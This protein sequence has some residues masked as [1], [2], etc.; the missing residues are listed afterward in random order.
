MAYTVLARRYRSSNFDQVI[1][2]DH[3]AQTLKKAI[4]T[5]RIAHAYLFCGTRGVGK[6]SMARILAKALNCQSFP[7]P[8]DTPCGTCDSCQAIARGEDIDVIEIDAAS[9]TGVDNVRDVI[10]N[11]AYRPVRGRFKIFIIDEVHMLSKQAFN[12]LL[13]TLEEPPEHVKFILAT[14]E[15][16]KLPATILSRCQRYD[17]RNISAREIAGHL[18]EICKQ[19]KIDADDDA[20]LLVAKAGCGSMRDALSLLDRLLSVGEKHVNVELVEQLLGLPKAQVLFDLAEGIAAADVPLTLTRADAIVQSGMSVD[21]LLSALVDHLHNLLILRT[22]GSSSDLVEVPGLAKAEMDVQ[23]KKFDA[24]VLVQDIAIL[25]ELRRTVR[26]SQAGRALL[27]ATLVR[28]ALADQ[29]ASVGQL[30]ANLD[31]PDGAAVEPG[32]A[33]PALKKNSIELIPPATADDEDDELPRPGKVFAGPKLSELRSAFTSEPVAAAPVAVAAAPATNIEPVDPSDLSAVHQ[34]LIGTLVQ[35]GVKTLIGQARLVSIEDNVAV[36]SFAAAHDIQMRML[37]RNGKKEIV[38]DAL[39]RLLDR[40]VGVKIELD[41]ADSAAVT[42]AEPPATA[43]SSRPASRSPSEESS[44]PAAPAPVP[45]LNKR[46]TPEQIAA[47][48]QESP[49]I[50]SLMDEMGGD[51]QRIDA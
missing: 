48:R 37:E 39:S 27:D 18:K 24:A 8:T 1:G 42:A 29:F 40:D 23:A 16:E 46:P 51:V 35:P 45:V 38:R 10:S 22:C 9:N 13:K 6:T 5:G 30:L 15:P 50:C 17:F 12:A 2:Q 47:L 20:L 14:T 43:P 11:A 34:A 28:L 19:E 25:E 41:T 21:S 36:F 49:L 33:G 3:V 32:P 7:G 26:Q 4:R 31:S 44:E